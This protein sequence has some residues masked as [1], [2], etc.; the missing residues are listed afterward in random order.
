MKIRVMLA[1]LAMAI[2]APAMAAAQTIY[3]TGATGVK[4][5]GEVPLQCNAGLTSCT[6]PTSSN[7]IP[8][9][10]ISGGSS[11][12]TGT[13]GTPSTSVVTVQGI[14]GGTAQTVG[15]VAA[16]GA[17]VSGNPVYVGGSKGGNAAPLLLNSNNGFLNINSGQA[18]SGGQVSNFV[19]YSYG[20]NGGSAVFATGNY[21]MDGSNLQQQRGDANVTVV[22]VGLTSTIWR[23]TSG[24]TPIL[25]NT[26][27][28]VT[29]KAAGGAGVKTMLDNCQLTTTAFGAAV[30]LVWRDGAAGTV[31]FSLIVPTAGYL[32]PISLY[33]APP[34][35]GTANTLMEVS[36]PTANTSGSVTLNCQGHTGA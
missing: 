28:A 16:T 32:Q 14:S 6:P 2:L 23:Y 29:I 3:P 26:T 20:D 34:L 36:T 12:P 7:P 17:A 30:P 18:L 22:G 10:V 11:V 35:V 31:M 21:V 33:F 15:G 25:S 19:N 13:A 27:T 4:V 9:S 5:P 8:V 1:A 24:T